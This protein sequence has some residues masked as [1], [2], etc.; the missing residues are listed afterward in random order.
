MNIYTKA[1]ECPRC[2]R[3][4]SPSSEKCDCKPIKHDY[5]PE[6]LADAFAILSPPYP[7]LDVIEAYAATLHKDIRHRENDE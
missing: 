7:S 2:R 1:W 3:W 5:C 4:H 6:C